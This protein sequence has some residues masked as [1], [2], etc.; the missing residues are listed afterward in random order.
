MQTPVRLPLVVS[1]SASR[2]RVCKGVKVGIT[3]PR[4]KGKGREMAYIIYRTREEPLLGG[5]DVD[6]EEWQVP[7]CARQSKHSPCPFS[8]AGRPQHFPTRGSCPRLPHTHL[9]KRK[10]RGC[11]G[12][13]ERARKVHSWGFQVS[14]YKYYFIYIFSPF[15]HFTGMDPK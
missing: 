2:R 7:V 14:F 11:L 9:K 3:G 15:T 10:H 5:P 8:R 1:L 6:Q 12:G 4:R 13:V